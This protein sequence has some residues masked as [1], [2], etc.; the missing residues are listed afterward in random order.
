MQKNIVNKRVNNELQEQ[1]LSEEKKWEIAVNKSKAK[2]KSAGRR[3]DKMV[4]EKREY[5]K[6]SKPYEDI[7]R[8]DF[9]DYYS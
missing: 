5:F 6:E 9:D 3:K 1:A 2:Y 4:G 7:K 8:S